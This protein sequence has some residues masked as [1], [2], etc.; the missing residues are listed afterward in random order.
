MNAAKLS[1]VKASCSSILFLKMIGSMFMRVN[2]KCVHQV[3]P[4]H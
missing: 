4:H 3:R 2:L 1:A